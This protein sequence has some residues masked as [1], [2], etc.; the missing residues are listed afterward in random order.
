MEWRETV[1][2]PLSER[3]GAGKRG[4]AKKGVDPGA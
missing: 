4:F 2:P 3:V 1:A